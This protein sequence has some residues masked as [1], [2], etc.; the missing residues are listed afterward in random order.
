L[1][2][3]QNGHLDIVKYLVMHGADKTAQ[4]NCAARW[5]KKYNHTDIVEYLE[6]VK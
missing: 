3:S 1:S 6:Q 4:N 5:A 2:A